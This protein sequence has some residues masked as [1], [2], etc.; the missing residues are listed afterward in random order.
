MSVQNVHFEGRSEILS[1]MA[2]NT[3]N[4]NE[5]IHSSIPQSTLSSS[6]FFVITMA[7]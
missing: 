2:N 7:I 1:E 4:Y 6:E 3:K 5:V